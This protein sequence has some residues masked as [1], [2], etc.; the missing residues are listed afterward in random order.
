MKAAG[1]TIVRKAGDDFGYGQNW[2]DVVVPAEAKAPA[3]LRAMSFA[4]WYV[5]PTGDFWTA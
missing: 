5:P 3:N 1:F 4:Y 2:D